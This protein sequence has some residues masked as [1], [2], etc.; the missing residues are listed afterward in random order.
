MVLIS[1]LENESCIAYCIG[2]LDVVQLLNQHWYCRRYSKQ[3][4]TVP[5]ALASIEGVEVGRFLI[6]QGDV[7]DNESWGP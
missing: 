3:D 2:H 5:L 6:E 7:W 1:T 4:S